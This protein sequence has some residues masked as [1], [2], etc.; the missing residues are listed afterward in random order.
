LD[1]YQASSRIKK[2][3]IHPLYL[4]SGP[5]DYLKEKLVQEILKCLQQKGEPV[6][7]ER[8]DGAQVSL[9]ELLQNVKQAT[10]LAGGRLLWIHDPPYLLPP[11][12]RAVSGGE[13]G[14]TS[15]R[16]G[17]GEKE[18]EELLALLNAKKEDFVLIF[19]VPK[20]DGHKKIVKAI[21]RAGTLVEFPVLKGALLKKWIK[22]ELLLE[23]KQ[24]EDN[25]LDELVERVG[26]NLHLLKRELEKIVTYMAGESKIIT[27]ELV[28]KL[29]SESRQG[30]IFKLV[31][32]VGKKNVQ[33]ALFH[34]DKMFQ[35]SEPPLII[36]AMII[37][38]FRLLYRFL[39]MRE[40]KMPLSEIKAS[41]K[42]QTF[43][44]QELARQ[45]EGYDKDSLASIMEKLKA[46]DLDIKTGKYSANEVLEQLILHLVT[47]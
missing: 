6:S 26:E 41:L 17:E 22:D 21:A 18:E 44:I 32:A 38:Q 20:V 27:L 30:N 11:S 14:G 29:V 19:S 2:G 16:T 23:K 45:A 1:Y 7:L 37:R 4:F 31:E 42:L 3:I 33:E 12:K 15:E 5:E 39:V 46:A 13:S 36:L 25:A 43:I 9:R 10:L 24:I 28:E 47:A 40:R 35:Q 8:L 34:L